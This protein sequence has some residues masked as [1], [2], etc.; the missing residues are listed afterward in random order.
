MP[1]WAVNAA[2]VLRNAWL[3]S[4]KGGIHRENMARGKVVFHANDNGLSARGD[5]GRTEVCGTICGEVNVTPEARRIRQIR[6]HLL[7]EL[8]RGQA[9]KVGAGIWAC[10]GI[11][12]GNAIGAKAR[13]GR[14]ELAQRRALRERPDLAFTT[15]EKGQGGTCNERGLEKLSASGHTILHGQSG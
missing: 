5:N 11:R 4:H 2:A 15:F 3:G 7:L 8:L 10:G 6:V 9:I 12:D 1:A 13:Q 14:Y